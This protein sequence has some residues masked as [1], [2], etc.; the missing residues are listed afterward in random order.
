MNTNFINKL[1]E[2]SK[3]LLNQRTPLSLI[4][5]EKSIKIIKKVLNAR[6]IKLNSELFN[7]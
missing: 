5:N 4:N 3:V 1:N 6:K 2:C 7:N